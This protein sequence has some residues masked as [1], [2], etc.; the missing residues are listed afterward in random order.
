MCDRSDAMDYNRKKK[1]F[2]SSSWTRSPWRVVV[3]QLVRAAAV[4]LKI[5]L[6]S[7]NADETAES[8]A[9]LDRVLSSMDRPVLALLT[10]EAVVREVALMNTRPACMTMDDARRAKSALDGAMQNV[11]VVGFNTLE[12]IEES[13]S[14][15]ASDTK[16]AAMKLLAAVLSWYNE[17]SNRHGGDSHV[18]GNGTHVHEDSNDADDADDGMGVHIARFGLAWS[19]LLFNDERTRKLASVHI[20]DV[21]ESPDADVELRDAAIGCAV[22]LASVS[23]EALA[24]ASPEQMLAHMQ[25]VFSTVARMC[26][27]KELLCASAAKNGDETAEK[28]VLGFA[29]VTLA[30]ATAL[31]EA[32]IKRLF[33][34]KSFQA[35]GRTIAF[36]NSACVA[37]ELFKGGALREA[38]QNSPLA[39]AAEGC[40]EVFAMHVDAC[41]EDYEDREQPNAEYVR[42]FAGTMYREFVAAAIAACD[43]SA[44]DPDDAAALE[45]VELGPPD[46]DRL[47]LASRIGRTVPLDATERVCGDVERALR[48]LTD[49]RTKG[50][51]FIDLHI[52]RLTVLIDILACYAADAGDGETPCVPL[53]FLPPFRGPRYRSPSCDFP[54]CT[55]DDD[56]ASQKVLQSIARTVLGVVA[57]C[58]DPQASSSGCCSAR[59]VEGTLWMAA[60]W[61]RTYLLPEEPQWM[62]MGSSTS[63]SAIAALDAVVTLAVHA[64]AS[65][66]GEV[67]LQSCVALLVRAIT[68][69]DTRCAALV[70]SWP[71]TRHAGWE[72]LCTNVF[73]R[74][75]QERAL[76]KLMQALAAAGNAAPDPSAYAR[77]LVNAP[78]SEINQI[79][80]GSVDDRGAANTSAS[81][82]R[83]CA[84]FALLRGGIEGAPLRGL[85]AAAE[86][87]IAGALPAACAVLRLRPSD[88]RLVASALKLVEATIAS[89]SLLGA[90]PG[91]LLELA[92]RNCLT[93]LSTYCSE[94][95]PRLLGSASSALGREE[96]KDAYRG[97]RSWLCILADFCDARVEGVDTT[98]PE[99]GQVVLMG[100]GAL[101]PLV[102]Q[103]LLGFPKLSASYFHLMQKLAIGYFEQ[104]LALDEQ[105]FTQLMATLEFGL[106]KPG[107]MQARRD[108][109]VALASLT[110]FAAVSLRLA[111]AVTSGALGA[112]ASVLG[113]FA[114]VLVARVLLEADTR[115]KAEACVD[116]LL[117]LHLLERNRLEAALRHLAG[118]HRGAANHLEQV[119]LL[120]AD[121][122]LTSRYLALGAR[123]P[124]TDPL[125]N[126][127]RRRITLSVL[128]A[129]HGSCVP[130]SPTHLG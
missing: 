105:S 129:A 23:G 8:T 62:E 69:S 120:S 89:L 6:S 126:D 1:R 58:S 95:A 64:L 44:Y 88:A 57:F 25:H 41:G 56:A 60:R 71:A 40:M 108:S 101:L 125:V 49:A 13:R 10:L 99:I 66:P 35:F 128:G 94:C 123:G 21:I 100:L 61:T 37:V 38:R 102:S 33:F 34:D 77:E 50:T 55:V 80:S 39:A 18:N 98:V 26:R 53:S 107:D 30:L 112:N 84:L 75:I 73:T 90:T 74:P 115:D 96:A 97:A 124:L 27:E 15:V 111:V 28:L 110:R 32:N 9:L 17:H 48:E 54:P 81:P 83:L 82:R 12:T 116:V 91:A 14:D 78:L 47:E 16:I 4:F 93:L 119:A 130:Q 65:W 72:A 76:R 70:G 63:P 7:T 2:V 59:L 87:A 67:R 113:K 31:R 109:L 127:Y 20:A 79:V 46:A 19:P 22:S 45:H 52:E 51:E 42:V 103:D 92:S 29:H 117:P 24:K 36:A 122:N 5:G 43:E 114:D 86:S 85:R 118:E 106:L 11:F 3:A 121:E 68:A 104:V